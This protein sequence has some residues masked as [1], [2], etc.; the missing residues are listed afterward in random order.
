MLCQYVN[1]IRWPSLTYPDLLCSEVKG[2][3]KKKNPNP[4][5]LY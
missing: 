1:T 5:K 3:D 4:D 2:E